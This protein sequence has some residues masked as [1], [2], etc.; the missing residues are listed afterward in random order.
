MKELT[1]EQMQ[2][3]GGGFWG[4]VAAAAISVYANRK[5]IARTLNSIGE[6]AKK[7]SHLKPREK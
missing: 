6:R 5:K 2:N 1:E 3:V 7:H 4:A